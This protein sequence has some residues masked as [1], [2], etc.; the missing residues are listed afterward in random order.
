MKKKLFTLLLAGALTVCLCACGGGQEQT[1]EEP[2]QTAQTE[3]PQEEEPAEEAPETDPEDPGNTDPTAS[4]ADMEKEEAQARYIGMWKLSGFLMSDGSLDMTGCG[5]EVYRIDGDGN[6][7]LEGTSPEGDEIEEAGTWSLDE[8][9]HIVMGNVVMGFNED[10]YLLKDS[11]E[12][13]GKG[14]K[15]HYAYSKID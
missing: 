14:F 10:G 6:Y 13:D 1:Q 2:Q 5:E 4:T 7:T 3:Q 11:G 12:R 15:L 8:T 9:N